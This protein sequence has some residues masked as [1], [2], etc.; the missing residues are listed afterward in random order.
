M[1]ENRPRIHKRIHS[2]I[3]LLG[4][5]EQ[6]IAYYLALYAML[7]VKE[8]IA[9]AST[10]LDDVYDR[11]TDVQVEEYAIDSQR[12]HWLITVSFSVRSSDTQSIASLIPEK[13]WKTFSIDVNT[14]EITYMVAGGAGELLR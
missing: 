3:Y 4:I 14:S 7:S 11:P 13:K 1:A 5:F 8:A 2:L 12:K 9:I 10:S 6:Q